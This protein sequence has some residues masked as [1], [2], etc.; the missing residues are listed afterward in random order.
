[1]TIDTPEQIA[2]EL[3][4]AGIGSRF[5]ALAFDTLIQFIL[6]FLSFLLLVGV[7]MAATTS[8]LRW[9]SPSAMAAVLVLFI[10]C[11]YWGYFAFF[12]IIWKGQT[13]GKRHAKIRVIKD[14]GRPLNVFEAIGR[15]L[16]R[17]IDLLPG[18]YGIGIVTMMLND[19]NRR[20]G[21]FVAGTVVVHDTPLQDFRPDWSMSSQ[22]SATQIEVSEL[23]SDELVIIETFLH[24]RLDLDPMV[25]L[26]TGERIVR[27]VKTKTGLE[28]VA[29]Q[30][31]EDFLEGIARQVRDGARYR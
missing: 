9:L 15:N 10:F 6:G 8:F 24:R 4:L 1:M 12:E 5:L 19:Q 7:S 14:T 26:Q 28:P 27:M 20:L 22:S 31:D 16:M 30:L 23:G 25:R 18:M 2:L 17:A 21:D 3:P 29:G 11:L 13:P